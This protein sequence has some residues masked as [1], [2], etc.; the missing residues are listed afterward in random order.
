MTE[1]ENVEIVD[2]DDPRCEHQP[3]RVHQER[4]LI[5]FVVTPRRVSHLQRFGCRFLIAG[6]GRGLEEF[7]TQC[8]CG[9]PT[10]AVPSTTMPSA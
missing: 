2:C 10:F 6:D 7:V 1:F 4:I 3:N 9:E 8:E 5:Q